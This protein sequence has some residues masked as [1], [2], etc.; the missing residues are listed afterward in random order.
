MKKFF[1]LTLAA[2]LILGTALPALAVVARTEDFYV[3]DYANVLTAKTK[4]DIMRANADPDGIVALC[5]GAQIVVVTI[6]YLDG[7]D[8]EEY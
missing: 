1:S 5:E 4:D 2:L 3:A 7:M 8:S 6:E